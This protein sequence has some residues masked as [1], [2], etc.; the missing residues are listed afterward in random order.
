[1]LTNVTIM[2]SSTPSLQVHDP[3]LA[4]DRRKNLF[5]IYS[6]SDLT[7]LKIQATETAHAKYIKK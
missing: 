6:T 4:I 3:T 5:F 7:K 1:M 2:M